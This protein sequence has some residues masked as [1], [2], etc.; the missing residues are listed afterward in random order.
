MYRKNIVWFTKKGRKT[1]EAVEWIIGNYEYLL[2]KYGDFILYL[3]SGTCDASQ[4]Q[5]FTNTL[6]GYATNRYWLS[7]QPN[8]LLLNR[9]LR[10]L[11]RLTKF[12]KIKNFEVIILEIPVY[13]IQACNDYNGY[14]CSDASVSF[15]DQDKKLHIAIDELNFEIRKLN[16]SRI[17]PKFN[18]DLKSTRIN[19]RGR[20]STNYVFTNFKDG[21]HPLP[22]LARY[23]LRRI[24]E[25]IKLS[26]Y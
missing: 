5:T 18:C 20:A 15:A 13:C 4:K 21:I 16:K 9:A 12:A 22:V 10:A 19:H 23:W 25:N 11:N 14:T 26:C 7:L 3:W 1:E 2:D 17:S 24:A 6:S 8:E